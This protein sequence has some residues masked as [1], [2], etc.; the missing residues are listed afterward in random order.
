MRYDIEVRLYFEDCPRIFMNADRQVFT[1]TCS[2]DEWQSMRIVSCDGDIFD[3]NMKD[4]LY[5]KCT[6][7]LKSMDDIL[8]EC[9]LLLKSNK[10]IEAIKYYRQETGTPLKESKSV[11]DSL[12]DGSL[13]S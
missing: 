10:K 7:L 11:V 1:Q 6:P 12:D 13:W 8:E 4:A 3:F 2:G 5:V 9:K